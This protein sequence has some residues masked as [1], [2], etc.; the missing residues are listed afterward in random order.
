MAL[1]RTMGKLG[2][3]T[4]ETWIAQGHLGRRVLLDGV[5]VT[6]RCTR[7][8]DIDGWAELTPDPLE[9]ND[10]GE[11]DVEIHRGVVEVRG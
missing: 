11:L 7:F 9:L 8:D 6:D 2:L 10:E 4:P 3:M 1:A 5:D